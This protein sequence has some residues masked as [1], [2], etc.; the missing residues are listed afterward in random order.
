[1]LQDLLAWADPRPGHPQV[2][3]R[4]SATGEDVGMVAEMKGRLLPSEVAEMPPICSRFMTNT[5]TRF[6][7]D[8]CAIA[9]RSGMDCTEPARRPLVGGALNQIQQPAPSSFSRHVGRCF[10]AKRLTSVQPT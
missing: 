5:E 7:R 3:H 4:R 10:A 6:N 2:F 8:W 1:M 9:R